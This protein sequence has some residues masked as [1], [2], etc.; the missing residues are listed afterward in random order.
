MITKRKKKPFRFFRNLLLSG[1]IFAALL[2]LLSYMASIVNPATFWPVAF[3]G[4]AYPFILIINVFFVIWW[5]FKSPKLALISILS[6]V[7][8]WKFVVNNIG[9]REST[10]I[11]VPKSSDKFLRIMTY[12]VHYFRKMD[13]VNSKLARDQM[14]NVVLKEQPDVMC[15]QE[16]MTHNNGDLN[17]IKAVKDILHSKYYYFIPANPGNYEQTG[18]AV[19]SKFP[20]KDKASIVFPNTTRGNEAMYVDIEFNKKPVRIY[21]V[22]FQS[23]AFQPDDYSYLKNVKEINPDVQSSKRIGSRLKRAFIKRAEQ[24]KELKAHTKTCP[25]PFVVAGDFNDTPVSFAV[26]TMANGLVNS[27]HEKGSGFGNTYNGDFPNFQIDYILTSPDF[28]IRNYQ[29]IKKKL[30]DH[31][32]VRSDIEFTK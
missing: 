19:F 6:I 15:F 23:I 18:L 4:L 5:L 32:P 13:N 24:V 10:A 3:I 17:T 29:I 14:L 21:N 16:F 2:L 12:N 22:H 28:E 8:G 11:E 9:F 27:F 20:I 31:Y 30:S 26:N 1:N 25:T 7:I